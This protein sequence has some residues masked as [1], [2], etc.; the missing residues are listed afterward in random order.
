VKGDVYA[1]SAREYNRSMSRPRQI[2][3]VD[4]DAFFVSVEELANPSLVGKPVVVGGDPDGRGVVS[5]ASYEA[6]KYG[7]RSAMPLRTAKRLCPRAIFL[8]ANLQDYGAWSRRVYR[9]FERYTPD[10]QAVSI[11]EAYLDLTG[12]E[13]LYGPGI[14]AAERIKLEIKDKLRLNASVGL[15]TNKLVAKVASELAK[16]NGLC[17]VLPGCEAS[18]L[19]P[20]KIG[21]LPGV[22]E[23]TKERLVALGVRRIGQLAQ[24]DKELL[25]RAFGKMGLWLHER[26]NGIDT[27][28]VEARSLPKSVSRET[29]FDE[30]TADVEKMDRTLFRLVERVGRTLRKEGLQARCLTLKLRYEDFSTVTR[31]VT[32]KEGTDLDAVIY[33]HVK[34]LFSRAYARRARV[35]L[36]GVGASHFT[37]GAWQQSFVGDL[38]V[39]KLKRLYR[40]IDKVRD[41]FGTDALR[42]GKEQEE[43]EGDD[44]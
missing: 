14:G 6:R 16:P 34:E 23:T 15:A 17:A 3:H 44:E 27:G 5:A 41:R 35:R 30:D 42:I 31:S 28:G 19:A 1:P 22:G 21:R 24:I 37:S 25:V 11:D 10:V 13:R 38:D 8:H 4:M 26:S 39:G 36:L 29:T 9:I 2:V 40:A 7:I 32:L 20:L 12:T 18:F 43:E 33:E